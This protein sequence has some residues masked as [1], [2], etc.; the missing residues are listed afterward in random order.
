MSKNPQF[1]GKALPAEP[2]KD[3]ATK[4]AN[5]RSI[6]I[7]LG[8]ASA[9]ITLPLLFT[10]NNHALALVAAVFSALSWSCLLLL[11]QGN[12][13]QVA[14]AVVSITLLTSIGGV[15]AL[16]TVRAAV[17]FMF[18]G[19]VA[20]AG[21]FLDRKALVVVVV[22]S[23]ASLS[24]LTWLETQGLMRA[25]DTSVGWSSLLVHVTT[26]IVV[27]QVVYYSRSRER[28]AMQR[29]LGENEQRRSV[30]LERDLS[31]TRFASIFRTSPSPMVAQ[32]AST[33]HILDVNPAF[34]RAYGYH[35]DQI[36]G[37][38]DLFLWADLA[39]R[40]QYLD[41]LR[42]NKRVHQFECEA[43]RA[44]GSRFK[45]L[46]SSE[47]GTNQ[48]DPL[49]MTTII[50]ISQQALVLEKLQRSEERFS[51]AFNFSPLNMAIT[52]IADDAILEV[53]KSSAPAQ[54]MTPEHMRGK[55]ALDL[56][57]WLSAE[58]RQ[59]FLDQL[60]KE[61]HILAH[62]TQ[63]RHLDGHLVNARVWAEPIEIDGEPCILSC[64][65]NIDAEKQREA[66]LVDIANGMAATSAQAYFD[67][68]TR[69]MALA[70]KAD[71]VML[72]ELRDDFRLAALSTFKEG[73]YLAPSTTQTMSGPCKQTLN[74]AVPYL[75]ENHLP[76][77]FVHEPGFTDKG[78]QAFLGLALRDEQQRPI[79]LLKA[80]WK[81]PIVATPDLQALM[82]IY[83]SRANA[84][85]LR[86]ARDREIQRLNEQLEDRVRQRTADLEKLN[87]EL[88]SFAYSV[89]HDL[90]TPLRSIDGFTQLLGEKLQGRLSVE[91]NRLF[92]RILT[93]TQR[94]S[95][96]I[97]DLLALARVS[98]SSLSRTHVG[99]S[100]MAE[101][102][103]QSEQSKTPE[104]ALRWRVSPGLQCHCDQRLTRIALDN[105]LGNALKYTREQPS[106]LIEI[107]QWPSDSAH[108]GTFYVRDNGVGF[109]M[110]HSDKLFKPFQRLHM[111]NAF[112]GTGIGLAT[113]RRIVERHGGFVM[114]HAR[115]GQ[116]AIFAW[117]FSP[118]VQPPSPEDL[119]QVMQTAMMPGAE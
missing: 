26:L 6:V 104:R 41:R 13:N 61:G 7:L 93:S 42:A 103:L 74:Q 15:L 67:A 107:G 75:I 82:S 102:I 71:T 79:G 49:V 72:G 40:E 78:Y 58:D 34:E 52:R 32:S 89:S 92:V 110:V 39:H 81:Q 18:V 10:S 38:T 87:A 111:P 1:F 17:G 80:L 8:I 94:M 91:E 25:A 5:I 54:G 90:K 12:A 73:E 109:N 95:Q 118:E 86:L 28:L 16:G 64:T 115:E 69:H 37:R 51:K 3:D 101:Q 116:G 45:I 114:G 62:E 100:G 27:A 11:K 23:V 60:K 22:V 106:T 47:L 56:G 83:A 66:L 88:D 97:A 44:D 68:L 63:M 4:M 112:D 14:I 53:N 24:L 98:Q 70:L 19:A 99:L 105:L 57:F 46:L 2:W 31:N 113:V 108:A 59:A 119:S 29:L 50:D 21:I 85:L 77:A 30:E 36:L 55:K 48:S 117:S 65:V 20:A 96:L 33:G 35:Q 9:L 43:L 76:E 84:E